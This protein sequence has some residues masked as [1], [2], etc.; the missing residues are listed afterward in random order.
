MGVVGT[1]KNHL[2]VN[3]AEILSTTIY[4]LVEELESYQDK[5]KRIKT[6]ILLVGSTVAQWLSA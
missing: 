4:D 1:P 6:T 3:E 5:N 2:P